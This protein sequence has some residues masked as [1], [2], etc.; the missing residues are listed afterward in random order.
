MIVSIRYQDGIRIIRPCR[1]YC[2]MALPTRTDKGPVPLQD[3][4][5]LIIGAI[6]SR[7]PSIA[8]GCCPTG[9]SPQPCQVPR[10]KIFRFTGIPIYSIKV[11][12]RPVGGGVSRSSRYVG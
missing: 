9:K 8:L 5:C 3:F 6:L 11:V 4:G 2:A 7:G 1:L 12:S 10:S